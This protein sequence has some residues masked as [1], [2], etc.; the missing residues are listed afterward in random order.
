MN[1]YFVFNCVSFPFSFQFFTRLVTVFAEEAAIPSLEAKSR[2]VFP[3]KKRSLGATFAFHPHLQQWLFWP[4]QC[5]RCIYN[6]VK[7]RKISS[8]VDKLDIGLG[9]GQNSIIQTFVT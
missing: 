7:F 1:S 9:E 6:G 8:H 4:I 3:L 5:F 2:G